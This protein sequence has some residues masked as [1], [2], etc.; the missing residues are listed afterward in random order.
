[1]RSRK[2][3]LKEQFFG[4]G[5]YHAAKDTLDVLYQEVK[6]LLPAGFSVLSKQGQI[7][8]KATGMLL[9]EAR[10]FSPQY[11]ANGRKSDVDAAAACLHGCLWSC[12]KRGM[13]GHWRD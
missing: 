1:M 11:P 10:I 9:A 2:D 13:E 6:Q 12:L 8:A 5:N 3:E 7:D 4:I